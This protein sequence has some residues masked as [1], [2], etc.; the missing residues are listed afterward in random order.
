M[1]TADAVGGAAVAT[2]GFSLLTQ[3]V[4]A[5]LTWGGGGRC[6]CLLGAAATVV[7]DLAVADLAVAGLAVAGLAVAVLVRC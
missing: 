5:P 6:P 4:S 2:A 1:L 3:E 7:A